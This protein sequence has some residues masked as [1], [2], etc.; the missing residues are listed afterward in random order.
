MPLCAQTSLAVASA[1]LSDVRHLPHVIFW[2]WFHV[3]QFDVS[4]QTLK[5]EEDEFNKRDRPLPS[6]RVTLQSALVL[7]WLLVPGC[8]ALSACYSKE[9][10]YASMALCLLTYIYDEMGASAGHWMTRNIVNALGFVAFEAGAC[11]IAGKS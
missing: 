10:V 5:P 7:R 2:I 1:P 9:T 8:W 11:L 3:L 4:N 6:R